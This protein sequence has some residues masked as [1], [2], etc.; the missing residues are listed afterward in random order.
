M[1]VITQEMKPAMQGIIP[2]AIVTCSKD[3][4]PNVAYI[5][6]VYFVDGNH[7]ALSHQFFNKSIRNIRD[8]P[9]VC[10]SI[11]HPETLQQWKL[12]LVFDR[13]E[14]SGETFDAMEI[15][16][17]AIASMM[18]MEDVFRLQAAEIFEVLQVEKIGLS[19]ASQS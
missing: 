7:V 8:N 1:N 14:T 10:V 13:T 18:G 2:S 15:Q 6:Q 3:G 19:P 11:V 17:E 16:L 9:R 5:S 12:H 4:I